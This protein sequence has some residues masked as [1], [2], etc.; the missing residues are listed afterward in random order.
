MMYKDVI[1]LFNFHFD[2]HSINVI[3]SINWPILEIFKNDSFEGFGYLQKNIPL[4]NMT[5]SI[6]GSNLL[7]Y[8]NS[9]AIFKSTVF[10]DY[11]NHFYVYS[12]IRIFEDK[13]KFF[14]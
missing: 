2:Y 14:I 1:L 6:K 11:L 12:Y 8:S 13:C 5:I 9:K 7:K 4:L 10:R 3:G